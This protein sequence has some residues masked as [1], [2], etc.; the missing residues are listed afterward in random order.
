[1]RN[2]SRFHG[3]SKPEPLGLECIAACLARAGYQC[4]FC[5]RH[6]LSVSRQCQSASVSLISGLTCEWGTVLKSAADARTRNSAVI[7]G[8]YHAGEALTS[9]AGTLVDS[10]VIGEGEEASVA[11][12]GHYL[13]LQEAG[14]SRHGSLRR[15]FP[16]VVRSSRIADLDGLPFPLRSEGRMTAY[17]LCD[18]MWPAASCQHNVALVLASRGCLNNCDFCASST[19]WGQGVRFRSPGNIVAELQDLKCQFET[20][21]I[22]IID[23]SFGQA[24][25][26]TLDVCQSIRQANLGMSWYHQSN[27]T[28]DREVLQ[29]MAEAGCT[30]IG[31]GLEGISP[32]A[33][34]RIKPPNP[35][36]FDVVNDLFDFCN[37]LGMFVK[38]YLMI[39]FPWETEEIVAEYLDCIRR[40]RGNQVKI[41]YMTP[42][43]GTA[44]WK[45]YSGQLVSRDW[46]DFDTVSMP[47]VYN[48]NISVE[49]YHAI[50]QA[51]FHTYYSSLAYAEVTE[52]MLRAFPHYRQSYQE[53]A[54]YLRAHGMVTG[55]EVWLDWVGPVEWPTG[56]VIP[57]PAGGAPPCR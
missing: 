49:R 35:S 34:E 29:A 27:L 14:A 2:S 11:L 40:L 39:G 46:S 5:S 38:I 36:D 52:R 20:N 12:V 32:R 6:E 48:P 51:L 28:V 22:V 25:Q 26:W 53:F 45:Q 56:V 1:M 43:P 7:L 19:V 33:V 10:I 21:A 8:G 13:D 47:V 41:S 42:F 30:K 18:L 50:R 16:A 23:Q 15:A 54:A 9:R 37:S 57:S 3:H 17:R 55:E 31:F 4:A 24:K 44:Y